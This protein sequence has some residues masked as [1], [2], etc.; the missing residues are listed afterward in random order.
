MAGEVLLY[1]GSEKRERFAR[2]VSYVLERLNIPHVVKQQKGPFI[3]ANGVSYDSFRKA[4]A[5]LRLNLKNLQFG[6]R[7][8]DCSIANIRY[9]LYL[10]SSQGTALVDFVV[11]L[12]HALDCNGCVNN[13]ESLLSDKRQEVIEEE[14][15]PLEMM[16]EQDPEQ[17]FEE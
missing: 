6:S 14:K 13:L 17:D 2:A 4:F 1:C 12:K 3:E 16:R 9:N 10:T 11:A 15:P 8:P 5:Y 7:S